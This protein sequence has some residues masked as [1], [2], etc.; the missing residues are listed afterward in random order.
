MLKNSSFEAKFHCI[1]IHITWKR[2]ARKLDPTLL[3]RPVFGP[4]GGRINGVPLYVLF[5]FVF[6]T[7]SFD[8]VAIDEPGVKRNLVKNISAQ[9]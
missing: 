4:D 8:K 2:P 9:H 3:I 6:L 7:C 5:S 1:C